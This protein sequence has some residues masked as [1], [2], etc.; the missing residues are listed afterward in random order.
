MRHSKLY[1]L[2]TVAALAL[3]AALLRSPP[4]THAANV[5]CAAA[6]G[7]AGA[8]CQTIAPG[9]PTP[10]PPVGYQLCPNSSC[11]STAGTT[12][13]PSWAASTALVAGWNLDQDT[14]NTRT[15]TWGT[16]AAAD[17]GVDCTAAPLDSTVGH[18][19]EG[20]GGGRCTTGN[21][22]FYHTSNADLTLTSDST[23]AC[24]V[25]ADSGVDAAII[26]KGGY[27][28]ATSGYAM[29]RAN[30]ATALRCQVGTGAANVQDYTA[31]SAP[32]STLIHGACRWSSGSGKLSSCVNGICSAGTTSAAPATDSNLFLL[33]AIGATVD[34]CTIW[35]TALSDANICR[36]A[37]CG[38]T[39]SRCA[40]DGSNPAAYASCTTDGDCGGATCDTNATSPHYHTCAGSPTVF[41]GT[42]CTAAACN[43]V[44]P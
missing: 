22:Q 34:E 32:A 26:N 41:P 31:S 27:N 12:A 29:D 21:G 28:S 33:G 24:F 7:V 16:S 19:L 17:L 1:G 4:E 18:Y 39:G 6:C 37:R 42:S 40:C 2:L 9:N 38:V 5:Y 35:T 20:A 23:W 13:A 10:T 25:Y 36:L 3:G 14:L 11:V 43:A 30:G 8:A 15:K 44:A